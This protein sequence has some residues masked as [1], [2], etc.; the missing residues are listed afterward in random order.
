MERL[1]DFIDNKQNDVFDYGLPEE[2]DVS[3]ILD[4]IAE[5]T[6]K[7]FRDQF[8][9]E[10]NHSASGAYRA[11]MLGR[12]IWLQIYDKFATG[13]VVST[14][15]NNGKRKLLEGLEFEEYIYML[16]LQLGYTDINRQSSIKTKITD[17]IF[18]TGH[19]DFIVSCPD[20]N[21]RFIIECKEVESK[22]FKQMLGNDGPGMQ[23]ETQLQLY[24]SELQLPGMW[25]I[26]NRDTKELAYIP[27]AID[28]QLM[29]QTFLY[30]VHLHQL[31]SFEEAYTVFP[32]PKPKGHARSEYRY[33]PYYFYVRKGLLH[34]VTEKLYQ[35]DTN[36]NGSF[37]VTGY[38]FPEEYKEYEPRDI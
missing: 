28:A 32:V 9:H 8:V 2:T 13:P 33:V 36:E 38:N 1:I 34:P 22:R 15:T 31:K 23:Y 12:N 29:A 25:I 7:N 4:C 14:M 26:S 30:T 10:P 5:S 24:M 11:S 35:I 3:S 21:K 27:C 20:T 17:E 37:I 6:R 16:L 19:P 18:V